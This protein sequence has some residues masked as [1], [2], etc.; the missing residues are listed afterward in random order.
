MFNFIK[1]FFSHLSK[2]ERVIASFGG[3]WGWIWSLHLMDVGTFTWDFFVKGIAGIAMSS[4]GVF[5]GLIVKDVYK[6]TKPKAIKYFKEKNVN[7][8][9]RA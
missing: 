2:E 9:R 5:A 4:A 8:K 3:I 7:R 6:Y 1:D